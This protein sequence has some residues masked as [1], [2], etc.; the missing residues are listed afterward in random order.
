[1]IARF[2]VLVDYC[3]TCSVCKHQEGESV[4][5]DW[6]CE[7]SRPSLPYGWMVLGRDLL[8][9]KHKIEVTDRD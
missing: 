3:L 1:M 5:W 2:S 9:P 4:L 8:C 7:L 6:G